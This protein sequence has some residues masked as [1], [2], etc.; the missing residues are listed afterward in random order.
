MRLGV[1]DSVGDEALPR[2]DRVLVPVEARDRAQVQ[3]LATAEA[4]DQAQVLELA[5]EEA[6][7]R[8]LQRWARRTKPVRRV[9]GM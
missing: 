9:K 4:Q 2:V 3:E 5:V 6:H 1:L 7:D 8:R